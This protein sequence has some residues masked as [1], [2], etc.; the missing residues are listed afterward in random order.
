[1]LGWNI[2]ILHNAT[3]CFEFIHRLL[4]FAIVYKGCINVNTLLSYHYIMPYARKFRI[5]AYSLL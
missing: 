1:M 5:V 2:S 3:F 4:L